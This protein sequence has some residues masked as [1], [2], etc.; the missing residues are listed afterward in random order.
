MKIRE[1][2]NKIK[3]CI[4]GTKT[5]KIIFSILFI[6]LIL[7]A[8][9]WYGSVQ[10]QDNCNVVGVELHGDLYTYLV[11][12]TEENDG[13]GYDEVASQDIV[14][15]IKQA[16]EDE[17]VKAILLEVDSR[18]GFPISGEEIS[19]AVK[20]SAKPVVGLIRQTGLSSSYLAVSSAGKIFASKYSDV[21]SIGVTMS[22]LSNAE[23][24]KMEGYTYEQLSSG[25]FKDAGSAD[26]PLTKEEKDMFMRDINIMYE[27]FIKDVSLNRNIPIEKIRSF[28]DGSSV[29]GEEAKELGLIDEIGG[30]P[31]VENYLKEL[32]KE[33]PEICWE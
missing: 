25:K 15:T 4:W 28:T 19:I 6:L 20:N 1:K 24:N 31:E 13:S 18:G 11:K 5:R 29:L 8:L 32:I 10:E 17:N 33:K 2:L 14:E 12:T 16:N 27:N 7:G 23:K 26:K 3:T 21:G 22:Y 9:A 30:F